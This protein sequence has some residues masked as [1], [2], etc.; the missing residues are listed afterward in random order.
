MPAG[1][2][3][4]CCCWTPRDP[5]YCVGTSAGA[6][7]RG[8]SILAA[9]GRDILVPNNESLSPEP[10]M[11]HDLRSIVNRFSS[12]SPRTLRMLRRG[13]VKIAGLLPRAREVMRGLRIENENSC[14][15]VR[16]NKEAGPLRSQ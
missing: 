15:Y 7:T 11:V 1:P 4:R 2:D 3:G 6:V 8:S 10:E 12:R 14:A 5:D 13:R 9:H 16:I